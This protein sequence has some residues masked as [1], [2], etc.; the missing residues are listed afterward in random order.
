MTSTMTLTRRTFLKVSVAA[1]GGLLIGAYWVNTSKATSALATTPTPRPI[2]TLQA[3]PTPTPPA[4]NAF[5]PNLFVKIDLDGVITLTVHRSEMGQGVRTALAMILAEELEADWANIQIEQAPANGKIGNQVTSGSGSIVEAYPLL[6]EAG[7]RARQMLTAAAAQ[8]WGVTV[9]ECHAENSTVV[10]TATGDRL[11]YSALVTI[12]QT[13]K[14]PRFFTHLKEPA[15]FRL[16]GTTPPRIDGPALV[17]GQ[18]RYGLDVRLPGMLFATIARCPV[19]GGT[20]VSY[21]AAKAKAVPGVRAVVEVPSGVAVVAEHTWAALQGR[22]ALS[23]TWDEGKQRTLSSAAIQQQ[24][25]DSIKQA[26]A[27]LPAERIDPTHQILEAIY[28][29]AYVAHVPM[30]PMNCVADVGADQCTVWAPTQNPQAAQSAVRSAV[31]VPTTVH[32]P[33]LGGGF[34]RRLEVDYAVEAALV[35]QAVQA[36]V[37]VVWTRE[38]D[39]QHD[40]Y[41]PATYHWLRAVCDAKGEIVVWQHYL[42]AQ[43]LNG[44]LYRAG[45][46]VMADGLPIPYQVGKQQTETLLAAIDLPT[47]PWRAVFRGPNVFANECFLDEVATALDQDPYPFRAKLLRANDLMHPVLELAATKAGWGT[48]LPSGHGRGIACHNYDNQVPVAMVA[49]VAVRGDSV[50]V[51]RVVCALDC[52]TVIHPDMVVQQMEGAIVDGLNT[53]LKQAI[54]FRNGRVE[55]SNFHDYPLLPMREMPAVEVYIQPS[56]RAPQGVGEMGVPPVAPAVA[57][58]IFAATGKRIRRLPA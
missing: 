10:R 53:L 8:T 28:E 40:F 6:R 16:I 19:P 54:T 56:K 37:Q 42:A 5:Q 46:E 41:R 4:T 51:H 57:N 7:A 14:M 11:G 22:N 43:S 26:Q 21:D 12:V 58:A 35:S 32:V 45:K 15:T 33:L 27:N 13:M 24:L 44:I 25:A 20:L 23:I 47:G 31:G 50:R 36:P 17:T 2:S 38:D 55:Q 48:A 34:G 9:E 52:G 49:E 18:A 29:T 39:I 3:T 1:S 30:E